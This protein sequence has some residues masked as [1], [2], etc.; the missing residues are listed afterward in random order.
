MFESHNNTL[1][2][3]SHPMHCRASSQ[4]HR[5]HNHGSYRTSNKQTKAFDTLPR[6]I[7]HVVETAVECRDEINS[8]NYTVLSDRRMEINKSEMS[9]L[10]FS[11]LTF[12]F[13][14]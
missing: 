14:Q 4:C 2:R 5:G 3:N 11:V 12:K 7:V 6:I 1:F 13:R 8:R 9:V 10:H